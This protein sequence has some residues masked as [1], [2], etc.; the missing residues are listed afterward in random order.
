LDFGNNNSIFG[1]LFCISPIQTLPKIMEY[2]VV[3]LLEGLEIL[4]TISGKFLK[5][6]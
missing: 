4:P 1:I 6:F 3:F 5:F 2:F